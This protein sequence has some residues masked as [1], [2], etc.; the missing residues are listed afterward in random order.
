MAKFFD[1]YGNYFEINGD[2]NGIF[3]IKN[4]K[5]NWKFCGLKKCNFKQK[6]INKF[7]KIFWKNS[8]V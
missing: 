1:E 7:K 8:V 6:V 2:L 4:S 3:L 5:I